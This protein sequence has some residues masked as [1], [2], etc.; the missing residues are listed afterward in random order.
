MLVI[1]GKGKVARVMSRSTACTEPAGAA[2]H[3]SSSDSVARTKAGTK[4]SRSWWRNIGAEAWR[5]H[6]QSAPSL[7]RMPLPSS[8]ASSRICDS[9]W[10][11]SR[12]SSSTAFISA[13]LVIHRRWT[14]PSALTTM[15]CS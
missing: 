3:L 9:F 8:G 11:F 15:S 5:C 7:V 6:F 14:R 12:S 2:R 4:P 1:D 13:G 10:N